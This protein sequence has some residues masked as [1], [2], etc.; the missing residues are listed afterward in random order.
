MESNKLEDILKEF[1]EFLGF[2]QLRTEAD[3]ERFS[4]DKLEDFIRQTYEY[5]L[6]QG[7]EEESKSCSE[8]LKQMNETY[9]ADLKLV[10]S[11]VIGEVVEIAPNL[12]EIPHKDLDQRSYLLGIGDYKSKIIKLGE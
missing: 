6:A 12:M 7:R 11:Q 5:G 8:A 3:Q 10:R 2:A 9:N 4:V 1:D